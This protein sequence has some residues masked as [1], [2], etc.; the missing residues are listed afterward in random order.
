[1]YEWTTGPSLRDHQNSPYTTKKATEIMK[2]RSHKIYCNGVA[3]QNLQI[4]KTM[5]LTTFTAF[6]LGEKQWKG[7]ITMWYLHNTKSSGDRGHKL[8]GHIAMILESWALQNI[9]YAALSQSNCT[10]VRI[11]LALLLK[12]AFASCGRV[13]SW[14]VQKLT[15]YVPRCM[16]SSCIYHGLYLLFGTLKQASPTVL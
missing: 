13:N 9:C 1:M 11:L 2:W 15:M 5:K 6:N 4:I 8:T 10:E 3:T 14:H 16:H 12:W 7:T